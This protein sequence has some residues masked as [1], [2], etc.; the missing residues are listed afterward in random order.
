MESSQQL[1]IAEISHA[2][3][4]RLGELRAEYRRGLKQPLLPLGQAVDPRRENALHGR[5]KANLC[6]G[7]DQA[8]RTLGPSDNARLDQRLDGLLDEEGI[9]TR[10]LLDELP[11]LLE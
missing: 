4:N 11:E 6:C 3:E 5:G 9:A 7:R 1:S 2:A 8:V 10:A